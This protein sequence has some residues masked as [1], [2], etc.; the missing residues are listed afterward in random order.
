MLLLSCSLHLTSL[1]ARRND[2]VQPVLS[3][4]C[5]TSI[6]LYSRFQRDLG[7]CTARIL[8]AR[9]PVR[10]CVRIM[11]T[12]LRSVR[13]NAR[14]QQP[15]FQK[16]KKALAVYFPKFRDISLSC[17]PFWREETSPHKQRGL[18]Y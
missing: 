5:V 15:P 16:L 13:G 6:Q 14:G 2:R 7:P 18:V 4:Q 3:V 8:I 9:P 17:R 1:N 11:Y 10:L 12:S